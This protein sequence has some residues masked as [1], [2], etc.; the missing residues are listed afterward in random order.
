VTVVA[1]DADRGIDAEAARASPGEH[2]VGGGFVEEIVAARISEHAHLNGP[3]QRLPVLRGQVGGFTEGDDSVLVLREDPVEHDEVV[4]KVGVQAGAEPMRKRDSAKSSIL[5]RT[6]SS[7]TRLVQGGTGEASSGPR[8]PTAGR[9][10]RV[11]PG[12]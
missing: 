1:F 5:D 11:A 2:V 12:P 8:G 9:E 3:L 10:A 6:R 7:G 4:V